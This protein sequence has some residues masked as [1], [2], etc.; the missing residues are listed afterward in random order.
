[1]Y[2]RDYFQVNIDF[3]VDY[4]EIANLNSTINWKSPEDKTE[5]IDL[6]NWSGAF[7]I[8]LD[9]A[10]STNS[11]STDSKLL[12]HVFKWNNN[13]KWLKFNKIK[14]LAYVANN[15]EN[16]ERYCVVVGSII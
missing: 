14:R 10:S 7:D 1:M 15:K 13:Q 11:K 12:N 3:K 2:L 8:I 9:S 6:V 5:S 4:L 16:N